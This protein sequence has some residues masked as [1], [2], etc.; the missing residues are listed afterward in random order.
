MSSTGHDLFDKTFHTTNVWLK[1]IEAE[2]GPDR[3]VAWRVLTTVLHELRDRLPLELS[4]H[5]GSQLP[6]I[7]RGAYYD[8]YKPSIQP[9]RGAE[10][11]DF[12]AEVDEWLQ[13][14]RPVDPKDAVHAVFKTLS[15]HMPNGQI[16]KAQNALPKHIRQRWRAVEKDMVGEHRPE[17]MPTM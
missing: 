11:A 7:V 5:F 17:P 15:R 4:A 8:Q 2:L 12:I 6:T 14:I 9:Q 3:K 10:H 1:E 16:T 13:D